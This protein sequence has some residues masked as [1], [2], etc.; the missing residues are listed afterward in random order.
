MKKLFAILYILSIFLPVF[1]VGPALVHA[2]NPTPCKISSAQWNPSGE[3]TNGWF[4]EHKTQAS[5][6]VTST[7]CV[8]QILSF[9]V[10]EADSCVGIRT[11][12]ICDD[13][14]TDSGLRKKQ[15]AV[16]ADNF[17]INLLMGEEECE[18]GPGFD[19]DVY[20]DIFDPQGS[21]MYD[22]KGETGGDLYYECDGACNTNAAYLGITSTSQAVDVNAQNQ[23]AT[24]AQANGVYTPLAPIGGVTSVATTGTGTCASN[25][26]LTNG[27]GCYINTMFE[28][29]IGLCAALAVI[30]IIINAFQYM[31]N[32]SVFGKVEA[33]GKMLAA[34]GG[35]FIALGA[36]ALL[37]TINPDLTGGGGL[38]V[39]AAV[40]QVDDE[41]ETAPP[42][43]GTHTESGNS[44][45]CTGSYVDVPTY[46][47]PSTINVCSSIGSVPIATNLKNMINAAH[48][49]GITLSGW[50]S[51]SYQTQVNLRIQHGCSDPNAPSSRCH[52]PT[53]RPGY[54]NH[55]IGGAV[56]FTCGGNSI[57]DHNNKCYIWLSQNAGQ[58][59][60][61]NLPSEPWH[62]SFNHK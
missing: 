26:A 35:L 12:D 47:S 57:S 19:C 46:G 25:P 58:Y 40:A 45:Q 10:S 53:A 17:T 13:D 37:N 48:Q 2:D 15:I 62:W 36:Y 1:F 18:S 23:A 44:K 16:P 55:E 60:F 49:A 29:G 59:Q 43:T 41:V 24:Q 39:S 34:L 7:G 51:R 20:F 22:S 33:K 32:E 6:V 42:A 30:M 61:Y 3:Q 14:L 11:G 28:I 21:T 5:I 31:G 9:T 4:I 52:P 50:G 8:G 38:S 54:S 27:I 56:D